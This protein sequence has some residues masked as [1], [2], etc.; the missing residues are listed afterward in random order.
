MLWLFFYEVI[1]AGFNLPL[2]SVVL[3]PKIL[4]KRTAFFRL[5]VDSGRH[6]R[7]VLGGS[8]RDLQYPFIFLE[9]KAN[10][11]F[12]SDVH[13]SQTNSLNARDN[14]K[15]I[16]YSPSTW[17]PPE[18]SQNFDNTEQ[19]FFQT[20]PLT[21]VLLGLQVE[22]LKLSWYFLDSSSISP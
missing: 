6:L 7:I 4:D 16:N 2:R 15:N 18:H 19:P 3:P 12:L 9:V 14:S 11:T 8:L 13:F 21:Q 17:K 10:K 22:L 1:S 20:D 5:L